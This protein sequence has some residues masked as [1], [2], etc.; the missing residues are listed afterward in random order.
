MKVGK[1]SAP[2]PIPCPFALVISHPL[3]WHEEDGTVYWFVLSTG[4]FKKLEIH[5]INMD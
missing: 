4:I 2:T 5:C 3:E 1:Q